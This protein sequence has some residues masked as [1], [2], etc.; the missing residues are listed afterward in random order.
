MGVRRY[1]FPLG[2]PGAEAMNYNSLLMAIKE[3]KVHPLDMGHYPKHP[4]PGTCVQTEW[5]E[6]QKSNRQIEPID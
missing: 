2:D 5:S 3:D 1:R 6:A 4:S